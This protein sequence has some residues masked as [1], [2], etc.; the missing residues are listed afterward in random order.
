M[1]EDSLTMSKQACLLLLTDVVPSLRAEMNRLDE[2]WD[3]DD[4]PEDDQ[5]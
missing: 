3:G 4:Y 2:M 1:G 5:F